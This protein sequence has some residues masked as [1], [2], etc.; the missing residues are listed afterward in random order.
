MSPFCVILTGFFI[1]VIIAIVATIRF[2]LSCC[3]NKNLLDNMPKY[4]IIWKDDQAQYLNWHLHHHIQICTSLMPSVKKVFFVP[5]VKWD[6]KLYTKARLELFLKCNKKCSRHCGMR[7]KSSM[8]LSAV[9]KNL[10]F[11]CSF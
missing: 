2:P 7:D 5:S 9:F 8:F 6:V 1:V 3:R 4:T 10:I 11:L